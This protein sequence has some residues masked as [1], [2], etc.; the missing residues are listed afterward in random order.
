VR[1][2]ALEAKRYAKWFPTAEQDEAEELYTRGVAVEHTVVQVRTIARTLFDSAV[3]GGIPERTVRQ[4]AEAL[5]AASMAVSIKVDELRQEDDGFVDTQSTKE[6]RIAGDELAEALIEEGSNEDHDQ[7]IRSIS[8]VTNIERIADSLDEST[9]AL[10]EVAL[11]EEPK[12][13]R[14]MQVNPV[15]QT[16]KLS[17]RI[18]S[19]VVKGFKKY[20]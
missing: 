4:M 3:S 5:S 20:F 7:F 12:S 1:A 9:P 17:E 8:I 19:S 6:V 16:V 14:I 10:T 18:K 13:A 15:T 2:Q 11:P